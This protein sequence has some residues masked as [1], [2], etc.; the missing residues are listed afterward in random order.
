M[1]EGGARRGFRSGQ[2]PCPTRPSHTR[3]LL[4]DGRDHSTMS[5]HRAFFEL[6]LLI[7]W[8]EA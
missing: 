2:D 8:V 3:N 6:G 1:E 4:G 5:F 7:M